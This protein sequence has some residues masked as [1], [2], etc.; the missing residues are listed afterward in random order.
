MITYELL[1]DQKYRKE[2]A[3]ESILKF[4]TE[5]YNSIILGQVENTITHKPFI[6]QT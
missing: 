4:T 5:N 3:G 1:K 6:E 2:N